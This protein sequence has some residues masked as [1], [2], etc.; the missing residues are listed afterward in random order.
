MWVAFE[1]VEFV[2]AYP[3]KNVLYLCKCAADLDAVCVNIE[4]WETG[5]VTRQATWA[6]CIFQTLND[7]ILDWDSV[8]EP[9]GIHMLLISSLWLGLWSSHTDAAAAFFFFFSCTCILTLL[10]QQRPFIELKYF[11]ISGQH[12]R[13]YQYFHPFI[14]FL[15]F[16]SL[17]AFGRWVASLSRDTHQYFN[18]QFRRS[19][20]ECVCGFFIYPCVSGI[21]GER[22]KDE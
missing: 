14:F 3:I 21:K 6:S 5:K 17:R 13:T 11:C 15:L 2:L 1:M 7:L 18:W 19:P 16:F 20:D 8:A 22:A 12:S 9:G 4:W 10:M